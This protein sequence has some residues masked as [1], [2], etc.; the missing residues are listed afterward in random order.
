MKKCH[1][2]SLSEIS[3][4]QKSL[5]L[6]H[7]IRRTFLPTA[8]VSDIHDGMGEYTMFCLLSEWCEKNRAASAVSKGVLIRCCLCAK[9]YR[10]SPRG[11]LQLY[12]VQFIFSIVLPREPRS[13]GGGLWWQHMQMVTAYRQAWGRGFPF[14]VCLQILD[15]CIKQR[16]YIELYSIIRSHPICDHVSAFHPWFVGLDTSLHGRFRS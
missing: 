9:S 3:E 2:W 11:V 12:L 8:P 5:I 6:F 15:L 14:R 10:H 16:L 4:F 13:L 1:W 7:K